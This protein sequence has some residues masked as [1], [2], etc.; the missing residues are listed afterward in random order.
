M[1]LPTRTLRRAWRSVQRAVQSRA[2]RRLPPGSRLHV[3]CGSMR[4]EGW[5][6][7][8]RFPSPAADFIYD[9]R[10]GM[11]ARELSYIYAEHFLEHLSYSDSMKFLRDCRTAL[12]T[13]GVLRLSTPNLDWVYRTQ[14]HPNEWNSDHDA[15]RDCF[16]M[17]KA[18]RAW[19]H[20]FLYNMPT[21][22]SALREAGFATIEQCAFRESKHDALRD[23]EQH[24]TWQDL[25]DLPHVLIVEAHGSSTSGE[26]MLE[27]LASDYLLASSAR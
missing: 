13:N 3:G 19:G 4:L 12:G 24:E 8:D 18:F 21:L 10:Y 16:W 2:L 5:A 14:Y 23:L 22:R 6:N 11:P 27:E 1:H 25:P 20:Q 9:V 15:V 26:P 17:N 7:I